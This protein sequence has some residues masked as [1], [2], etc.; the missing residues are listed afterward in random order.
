M[1]GNT[2]G[3]VCVSVTSLIII[4]I[5]IIIII[6]MYC[7]LFDIWHILHNAVLKSIESNFVYYRHTKCGELVFDMH[8]LPLRCIH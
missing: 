8:Y 3:H 2:S 1:Q 6:T 7:H 5:I 4:I